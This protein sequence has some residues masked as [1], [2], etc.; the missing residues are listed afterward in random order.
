MDVIVAPYYETPTVAPEAFFK[1]CRRTGRPSGIRPKSVLATEA[2]VGRPAV[3]QPPSQPPA[4]GRTA[5]AARFR[6]AS[7]RD[8]EGAFMGIGSGDYSHRS[9]QRS[10]LRELGQGH[11]EAT[12]DPLASQHLEEMV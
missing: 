11:R 2:V 10:S 5:A 12:L 9:G 1:V 3:A 7:R 8:R 6:R 4:T